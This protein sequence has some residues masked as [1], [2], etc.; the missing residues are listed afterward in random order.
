MTLLSMTPKRHRLAAALLAGTSLLPML[1]LPAGAAPP[2]ADPR[3]SYVPKSASAPVVPARPT[4]RAD[5]IVS[6]EIITLGDLISGLH[7]QDAAVSAFRAPALGETGT[8]QASRIM[9]TAEAKGLT[10]IDA[11]GLA[12]VVVTRAGRRITANDIEMAVKDALAERHGVDSRALSLVFDNGSPVLVVEPGLT[13]ALAA[14]DVNYDPRA[15]RVSA[16][17]MLPGSAAMRLKPARITG[18]LVETME[19]VVPLKTIARGE[20]L[21]ERDVIIERRPRDGQNGDLVSESTAAI[22]K[23]ARRQLGA[24]VPLRLSDIQRQEVIARGELVTMSYDGPGVSLSL[25]GKANEAGAPGDVISITNPTSKR[26]VQGTVIGPGRVS[27]NNTGNGT[28]AGRI[29]IA[30]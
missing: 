6:A 8:I 10:N 15:R 5:I 22:G 16:T 20:L 29:A 18:Q 3:S 25:R 19:V 2:K 14:L 9:A 11:S 27:V 28:G 24:G 23:M 4:L 17:V 7:P 1:A 12:Q 21:T 30:P 13:G 26:V